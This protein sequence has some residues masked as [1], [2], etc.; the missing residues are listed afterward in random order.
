MNAEHQG[1]K[2][3]AAERLGQGSR[4]RRMLGGLALPFGGSSAAN[5]ETTTH[6]AYV[7]GLVIE[8]GMAKRRPLS[9]F[10]GVAEAAKIKNAALQKVRAER[11]S[12]EAL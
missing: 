9:D 2:K 7:D 6:T 4:I 8:T 5:H 11:E 3:F 10:Y 1:E 12:G